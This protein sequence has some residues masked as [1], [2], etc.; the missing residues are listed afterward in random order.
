VLIGSVTAAVA[1][2]IVLWNARHGSEVMGP[3]DVASV[4]QSVREHL[5]IGSAR[6]AVVAYLDARHIVHS[7]V[8]ET[9]DTPENSHTEMALIRG[10]SPS[11]LVRKDIQVLFKFDAT[12]SK[13]VSFSVR[14]LF[15]GP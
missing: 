10:E 8:G 15:T 13:M 14:E 11:G 2:V 5:P 1:V 6:S 4:Q 7:H 12:D 3:T 9:S